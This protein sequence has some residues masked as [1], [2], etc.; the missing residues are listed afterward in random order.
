MLPMK[1]QLHQGI[2]MLLTSQLT[3][4]MLS[5]KADRV[6]YANAESE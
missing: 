1:C 2:F 4:D 3:A 5:L 6:N